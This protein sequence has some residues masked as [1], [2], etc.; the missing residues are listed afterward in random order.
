MPLEVTL[1]ED[2]VALVLQR[3]VA[4]VDVSFSIS[5][6]PIQSVVSLPNCTMGGVFCITTMVSLKTL[7]MLES[8]NQ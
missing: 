5:V 3:N 2:D 8:G 7:Q 1:I 6:E 4:L